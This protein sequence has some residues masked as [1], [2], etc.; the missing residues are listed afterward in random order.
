MDHGFRYRWLTGAAL[1]ALAMTCAHAANAQAAP[2]PTPSPTARAL[3]N[4]P[5]IDFSLEGQEAETPG[6]PTE[7][8][9]RP[10]PSASPSV[11]AATPQASPAPSAAPEGS[12]RQRAVTAPA[13]VAPPTSASNAET[14]SAPPQTVPPVD[15]PE[16]VPGDPAAPEAAPTQAPEPESSGIPVWPFGLAVL[17]AALWFAFLRRKAN[18]PIV[19]DSEIADQVAVVAQEPEPAEAVPAP[20][21]LPEPVPTVLPEPVRAP[22]PHPALQMRIAEPVRVPEPAPAEP[23]SVP[24]CP[25]FTRYDAFGR[26]ILTQPAAPKPAPPPPVRKPPPRIVRYNAMGLPI[27]D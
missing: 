4:V 2:A 20:A 24:A 19:E 9:A 7:G 11:P 26:P 25:A 16:L 13:Q 17:A 22:A 6:T 8:P 5:D 23:P 10:A 1:G 14:G 15:L 12:Q 3:P 21:E 18:A 27:I